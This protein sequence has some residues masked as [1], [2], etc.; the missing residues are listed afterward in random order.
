MSPGAIHGAAV[1]V[2]AG[3]LD[4]DG[5]VLRNLSSSS[6]K[7][8]G[9]AVASGEV[10]AIDTA[11]VGGEASSGG[12]LALLQDAAEG[13]VGGTPPLVNLTRVYFISNWAAE[14][15]GAVYLSIGHSDF[16]DCLFS[17]SSTAG[18]GGASEVEGSASLSVVSSTFVSNI[19]ADG[20]HGG[21]INFDPQSFTTASSMD[22]N[23][24]TANTGLST[25]RAAQQ[26]EWLCNPGQYAPGIGAFTGDWTGCPF[27]CSLGTYQ[28]Q[29]AQQ[30]Q[31]G[32]TGAGCVSCAAG[33]YQDEQGQTACKDCIPGNYCEEGA[34]ASLPCPAGT[35]QGA[36]NR[37][38]VAQSDCINT[39][40]GKY[41][42]AGSAEPID[43]SPGTYAPVCLAGATVV[44]QRT[45]L[46]SVC[47]DPPCD[48]YD[49]LA[50]CD[51]YETRTS[52]CTR[53]QNGTYQSGGSGTSC[54]NCTRG[55]YCIPGSSAPLPCQKGS[56][57]SQ[58]G[59]AAGPFCD[60]CPVGFYCTTRSEERRVGNVCSN[61]GLLYH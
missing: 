35:T 1:L 38:L 26:L 16:A 55:S 14:S 50:G 18:P 33:E 49:P 54:E 25:V 6:G 36:L 30:G 17:G 57:N 39:P 59:R 12:A 34:T 58:T 3:R 28:D 9:V 51:V 31:Q 48:L 23:T 40:P 21:A 5:V 37:T 60:T 56:F 46:S 41:A 15:G 11:F 61:R 10:H 43:C 32:S 8:G 44:A 29:T 24:F 19:A 2:G 42:P 53:C 27:Q 4:L 13:L 7:G 47:P 20:S 52:L 22:R 45:S